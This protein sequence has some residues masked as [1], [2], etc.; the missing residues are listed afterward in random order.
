VPV[1]PEPVSSNLLL[2]V[3]ARDEQLAAFAHWRVRYQTAVLDAPGAQSFQYWQPNPL[4]SIAVA[5]FSS[6]EALRGWRRSDRH[7]ALVTE[8]EPLV[9]GGIVVQL[10]GQAASEYYAQQSTTEVIITDIKPGQ[11]EPYRAFAARIQKVQETFPGY[12]GSFVQPPDQKDPSWTTVLRFDTPEHLEGWLG[13]KERAALLA[14]SEQLI[15]GFRAQRVDTSFPGWT[16]VNP[17]TGKP[18]N[19]WKTA[20]LVLLT[21]FPVVMLELKFLSPHLSG[22]PPAL[23]TFVGNALSVALT[24]WPLMPL[25]IGGFHAWLFPDDRSRW[26][27]YAGPVIVVLCYL[28]EIAVL[29]RLL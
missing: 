10:T 1:A 14:E 4:Q 15:H 16:P 8:A 7:R 12:L 27:A 28:V 24:T 23:A 3:R 25:A 17:K 11:E 29:W 6:P 5:R 19:M 20:S 13:S 9:E 18:P 21:L 2:C 26:L 22:L